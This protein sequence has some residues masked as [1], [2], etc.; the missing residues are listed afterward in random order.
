MY[1]TISTFMTKTDRIWNAFFIGAAANFVVFALLPGYRQWV[2]EVWSNPWLI[3][4]V[5]ISIA[6][7]YIFD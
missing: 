7:A 3:A 2:I 5:P 4:L 6:L 1:L